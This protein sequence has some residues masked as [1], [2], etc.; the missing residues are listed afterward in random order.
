MKVAQLQDGISGMLRFGKNVAGLSA[1]CYS[2]D[3]QTIL[4]YVAVVLLALLVPFSTASET[5]SINFV[6]DFIFGTGSVRHV[7]TKTRNFQSHSHGC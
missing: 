3:I 6:H 4:F 5:E 7:S 2:V 1:L